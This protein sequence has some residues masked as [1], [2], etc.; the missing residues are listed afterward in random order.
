MEEQQV[1]VFD[2]HQ[3]PLMVAYVS[4]LYAEEVAQVDFAG[5]NIRAT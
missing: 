5:G 3:N 4:L 1:S 2:K